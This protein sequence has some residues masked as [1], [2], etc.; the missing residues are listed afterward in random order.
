VNDSSSLA[1]LMSSPSYLLRELGVKEEIFLLRLRGP[2]ENSGF[3]PLEELDTN[4]RSR[5]C[6]SL[7][8]V[9]R[10]K[11]LSV[12]RLRDPFGKKFFFAALDF[13]YLEGA[14]LVGLCQEDYSNPEWVKILDVWQ[15]GYT[16]KLV[17]MGK[18][19]S[20]FP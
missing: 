3:V 1:A 2:G 20:V 10:G 17:P 8:V 11:R 14:F 12:L 4:I 5:G 19:P 13:D 6:A 16:L 18:F 7:A 9:R 15:K